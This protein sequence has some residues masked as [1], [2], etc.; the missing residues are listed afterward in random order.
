MTTV[1]A[2]LSIVI[3]LL[4]F[5][6]I[7]AFALLVLPLVVPGRTSALVVGT[8]LSAI[9]LIVLVPSAL[10]LW[11]IPAKGAGQM[12]FYAGAFGA[13]AIMT[14]AM[15]VDDSAGKEAVAWTSDDGY[16]VILIDEGVDPVAEGMTEVLGARLVSLG[17]WSGA[18][19]RLC[20]ATGGGDA[21]GGV[22][23][24]LAAHAVQGLE[25]YAHKCD[26]ACV[27]LWAAADARYF[28]PDA[29][30]NTP[31]N[32]HSAAGPGFKSAPI[33]QSLMLWAVGHMG[34]SD[35]LL[36]LIRETPNTAGRQVGIH[37]IESTG[38]PASPI[39]EEDY[40]AMCTPPS[41]R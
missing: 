22:A 30:G 6:P 11:R 29:E 17:L 40:R 8:V 18:P 41:S 23:A 31:L 38:L 28:V 21:L 26:S 36:D 16:R 25:L 3:S 10:R 4:I 15:S 2:A 37:E 34:G 14:S 1:R 5:A 24:G 7:A 9:T 27:N 39:S 33:S 13:V 19:V 12:R 20:V 32:V 35:R